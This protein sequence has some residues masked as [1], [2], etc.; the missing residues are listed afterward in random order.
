MRV[1]GL[2][3]ACA[4]LAPHLC[5]RH[6][7]GRPSPPAVPW[8]AAPPPTPAQPAQ[9]GVAPSRIATGFTRHTGRG[10]LRHIARGWCTHAGQKHQLK[11][12][13][14]RAWDFT[15]PPATTLHGLWCM[16]ES[17]ASCH[18]C[19]QSSSSFPH[20]RLKRPGLSST[21]RNPP[22]LINLGWHVRMVC[23]FAVRSAAEALWARIGC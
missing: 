7:G 21:T 16:K 3:Y 10:G 13:A 11:C 9:V 6:P 5:V 1:S 8:Q 12:W 20:A 19:G 22:S 23:G 4:A 18:F 15:C 2:E 14:S 17:T